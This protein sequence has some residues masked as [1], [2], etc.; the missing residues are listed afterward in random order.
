MLLLQM[1]KRMTAAQLA[2]RLGVLERTILRDM[3]ALSDAGIPVVAERGAGGGW[4]LI[5]GY[6]TQLTGLTAEE[7]QLGLAR[8]GSRGHSARRPAR[9]S[10][11]RRR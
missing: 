10:E 3:D 2:M 8:A 6:R 7:V 11:A 9:P 5:E 4:G 1:R